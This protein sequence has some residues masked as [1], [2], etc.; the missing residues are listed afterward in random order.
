MEASHVCLRASSSRP[1][2]QGGK[3]SSR[4]CSVQAPFC[5]V[6]SSL[7]SLPCLAAPPSTGRASG[8]QSSI[9]PWGFLHSP[10]P[11]PC[12]QHSVTL[13]YYP[14]ALLHTLLFH[15]VLC[16]TL[17]ERKGSLY[18]HHSCFINEEIG[19][20]LPKV[21]SQWWIQNL[22]VCLPSAPMC[23]THCG[24]TETVEI[25]WHLAKTERG[26]CNLL[27]KYW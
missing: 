8:F 9:L 16:I 4:A 19:K 23:F 3:V 13:A 25:L 11:C 6:L 27:K 14:V 10:A 12:Q 26:K 2:A 22:N 20:S 21:H 7:L 17:W 1:V 24:L 15:L 5:W 18:S